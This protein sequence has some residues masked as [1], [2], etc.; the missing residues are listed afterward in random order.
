MNLQYVHDFGLGAVY[1]QHKLSTKFKTR[2]TAECINC[3]CNVTTYKFA[4]SVNK[5]TN[6]EFGTPFAK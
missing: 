3:C 1:I 2:L 5:T 4:T 6:S